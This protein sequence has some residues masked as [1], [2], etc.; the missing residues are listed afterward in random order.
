[1]FNGTRFR[2]EIVPRIS[3]FALSNNVVAT[4]RVSSMVGPRATVN[5]S[6]HPPAAE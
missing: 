5:G 3:D 4:K 1:V 6:A 2:A